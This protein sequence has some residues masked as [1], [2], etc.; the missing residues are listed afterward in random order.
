MGK[1]WPKM[2]RSENKISQLMTK[3]SGF[4][5]TAEAATTTTAPNDNNNFRCMKKRLQL[6]RKFQKNDP[7]VTACK[8]PAKRVQNACKTR[9]L[10]MIQIRL[11]GK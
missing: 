9:A 5:A 11:C 6:A 10:L 1:K 8:T 7:H 3:I 4:T 2:K